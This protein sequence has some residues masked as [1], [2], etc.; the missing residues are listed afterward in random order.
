MNKK[1]LVFGAFDLL[2]AGHL[3]FFR[4]AKEHGN[5]LTVIVGTDKNV[6]KVKAKMPLQNHQTRLRAVQ[7]AP[8]VNKALIGAENWQ[9]I[10]TIKK[11]DPDIICL[12]YD[13][14]PT[15]QEL[16]SELEKNGLGTIEVVR[17][18]PYNQHIFK[19]TKIKQ[20]FERKD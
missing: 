19:S 8:Y 12:G 18:K 5:H 14:Q 3:D 6:S 9:Y 20:S 15:D 16:K 10:E 11:A 2:H 17:L 4:Q 7:N 1:V 13:Q